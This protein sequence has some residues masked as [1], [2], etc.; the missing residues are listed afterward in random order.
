MIRKFTLYD[1]EEWLQYD[2]IEFHCHDTVAMWC[3]V[4]IHDPFQFQP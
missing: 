4:M 2:K 3:A 1:L